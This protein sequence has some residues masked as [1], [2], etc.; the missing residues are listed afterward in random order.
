MTDEAVSAWRPAVRPDL[1][2]QTVDGEA[3][4]LD[5]ANER[6]HQLD[7]VGAFI[8]GCCDGTRTQDDIVA[9]VVDSYEVAPETAAADASDLL[10]RMKTLGILI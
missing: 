7:G 2:T 4:L 3:I 1:R 10:A 5:R 9:K 6:V 8:L